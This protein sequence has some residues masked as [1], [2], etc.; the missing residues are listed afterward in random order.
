MNLE[1]LDIS[2]NPRITEQTYT[3]LRGMLEDPYKR[4]R[5]LNLE[6]VNCGDKGLSEIGE[7]LTYNSHLRYLNLS[8]NKITDKSCETLKELLK[9]NNSLVILLLHWN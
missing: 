6:G 9:L 7:A 2:Y 5:Q 4:L 8:R 1:I 3:I